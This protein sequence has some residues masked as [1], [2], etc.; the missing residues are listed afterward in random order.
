MECVLFENV[1]DDIIKMMY[2]NA[3]IPVIGSG[4]TRNSIAK[5][6]KVPSGEEY[7]EYMINQ[8]V[9]SSDE[10]IREEDLQAES[11]SAISSIY[12]ELVNEDVQISY[13]YDNFT[14]VNIDTRKKDFLKINWPYIYTLNIDDGIENNSEYKRVLCANRD[15]RD[16]IFDNEKCLIK[17]HG[18]ISDITS[19]FDSNCEI[20]DTKQYVL[21]IKSNEALL[22]KLTHDYEFLNLIYIGCGLS[23][24][25]DLLFSSSIA[26]K[27]SNTR[28]YCTTKEPSIIEKY[29]LSNYGITHCIIFDSYNE[30]YIKLYKA[31]ISSLGIKPEEL[32]PLVYNRFDNIDIGFD[33]N[34]AYLFQGKSLLDNKGI[35]SF[36][37][38]FV[39]RDISSKVLEK[40]YECATQVVLGKGCSGKTYLAYD[41]AKRISNKEVFIF[42]T[43]DC[44]NDKTFEILLNK[45]NCLVICDSKCLTS[46]QIEIVLNTNN[47]RL[48]RGNSFLVIESKCNR[49]LPGIIEYFF[50]KESMTSDDIPLYELENKFSVSKTI[51]INK[52][53]VASSLG[54]FSENKT[55]ADNIIVASEKL[56]EDHKFSNTFAC[57]DS[58]R[59]V[60]SL[61]VLAIKGKVYASDAVK[62]DLVEE[63]E[64]QCS[65]ASP[66]IEKDNTWYF[67]ISA[68][69]NSP[70]KY[71]INAEYW[72]FN[73]LD[74]L[75][76][77]K[78]GRERIIS[79]YKYIIG[80]LIN[81]NGKPDLMK[82][83]RYVAY[84]DYILFDNIFQI[85]KNQGTK[86]IRQIFENLNDL[87]SSDPNFLHQKAK[88]F[89]R[90]AYREK[91]NAAKWL[92]RAYRDATVSNETFEKRYEE[93]LNEKVMISAAHALYT[94]SL[95]LCHIARNREYKDKSI[96]DKAIETLYRALSSPYNSIE[97]VNNDSIYNFNNVVKDIITNVSL[98]KSLFSVNLK[99][100]VDELLTKIVRS[101]VNA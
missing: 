14:K 77:E 84:K 57:M 50:E 51:E 36:P 82:S 35:I 41:I 56:I 69:N 42:R 59:D 22:K 62:L 79:S 30:I 7:K 31:Y 24:E 19:Y 1:E 90:S 70:F 16:K 95:S 9:K 98:N 38:F 12:H 92:E 63:F 71:I 78:N 47:K 46:E 27:N 89:I 67:E 60:A 11:F 17:L 15:I 55:I 6:G 37:C 10:N 81:I 100:K 99:D 8:I 32:K 65:I 54:V 86:I 28:Y 53:L 66:L 73:Q 88:C 45:D 87:L 80:K 68:G 43:K 39:S 48:K 13:L 25:I 33:L 75:A 91:D 21:S 101:N 93:S 29:K 2:R 97:F 26:N 96:N 23:D 52:M 58:V 4:F 61:I 3:L 44:I 76:K 18:D 40:I 72:L 5:N 74:I 64:K 94:A 20:F 34:K 83:D 85:F 49:D